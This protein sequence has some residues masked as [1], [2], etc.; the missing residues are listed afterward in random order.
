MCQPSRRCDCCRLCLGSLGADRP[1]VSVLWTWRWL[2]Q[3]LTSWNELPRLANHVSVSS[4]IVQTLNAV[5]YLV[6]GSKPSLVGPPDASTKAQDD[7]AHIRLMETFQF[8]LDTMGYTSATELWSKP[9]VSSHKVGAH[10][11]PGG[12]GWRSAATVRMLHGIAR[13]RARERLNRESDQPLDFVPVNQFDMSGT[14]VEYDD[15]F[16]HSLTASTGLQHSRPFRFG[17]SPSW[18]SPPPSARLM[19]TSPFGAISDSTWESHLKSCVDTFPLRTGRT[20]S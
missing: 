7:R 17:V 12:V 2:C 5:S 11:F 14:Y 16:I 13:R 4:R 6:S 19:P 9:S 3:V 10:I 18:A 20:S 1:R 15:V 8:F